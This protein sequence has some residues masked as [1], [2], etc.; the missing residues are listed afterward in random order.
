M[1]TWLPDNWSGL[2]LIDTPLLELIARGTLLYLAILALMRIM[3]RRTGGELGTMDL[4]F[5]LLVAGVASNAVGKNPSMTEGMVLLVVLM[6]WNYAVNAASYHFRA[7]ERL[8]A[9][10]AI[11]VVRN[12]KMIKR[13]MRREFLTEDELMSHLRER[14][15]TDLSQVAAAYVE[16]EGEITVITRQR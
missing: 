8:V 7:I 12:G 13:N 1:M 4:A 14:D 10:P 11:Q 9:A 6:A 15:I 3:P 2:F 5:L 16:S